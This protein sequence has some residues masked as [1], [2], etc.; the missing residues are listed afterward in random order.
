MLGGCSLPPVFFSLTLIGA[1]ME[2]LMMDLIDCVTDALEYVDN[3][4]MREHML[5]VIRMAEGRLE[6]QQTI[7]YEANQD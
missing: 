2:D 7:R 6:Y 3:P 1:I 5:G 4:K